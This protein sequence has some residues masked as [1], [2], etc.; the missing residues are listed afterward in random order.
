M[1]QSVRD[2]SLEPRR[3]RAVPARA[4]HRAQDALEQPPRTSPQHQRARE[5]SAEDVVQA[6]EQMEG[7][8]CHKDALGQVLRKIAGEREMPWLKRSMGP[9]G[10][11]QSLGTFATVLKAAQERGLVELVP[12]A[13]SAQVMVRLI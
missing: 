13:G 8:Q 9:R 5:L 10:S 2:S 6:L 1:D 3:T 11:A 4:A 7:S 12:S